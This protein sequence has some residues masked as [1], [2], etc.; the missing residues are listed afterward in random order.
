MNKK[1]KEAATYIQSL[2]K[3]RRIDFDSGILDVLEQPCIV[4]EMGNRHIAVDPGSGLWTGE[5]GKWR[6][7][8]ASCTVSGALQAIEFLIDDQLQD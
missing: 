8:E 4:I 7:I 3:A 1:Q 5:Q 6:C 2:L